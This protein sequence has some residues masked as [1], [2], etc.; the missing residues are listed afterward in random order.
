MEDRKTIKECLSRDAFDLIKLNLLFFLFCLPLIS[1]PASIVAMTKLNLQLQRGEGI[2]LIPDFLDAFR[3]AFFDALLCGILIAVFVFLFGYVFWFYQSSL[4]T[5]ILSVLLRSAT[6]LPLLLI[7]CATCY[8][9]PMNVTIDLSCFKRLRNAFSLSIICLRQ[10][11]LCLAAGFVFAGISF[12][13]MPYS[14]P[15]VL[16]IGFSYWNYIC[17]Y[18]TEPMIK[19]YVTDIEV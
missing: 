2:D 5:G 8:L 4:N 3:E 13:A 1:I 12:L 9:W 18:Y 11:L 16:V 7:Y 6:A 19:L 10:T 17:T 15:F 14:T